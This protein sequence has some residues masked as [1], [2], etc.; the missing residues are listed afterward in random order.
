MHDGTLPTLASVLTHYAGGFVKRPAIATHM[1]RKLRL[2]ARE[3][4]DLIAFLR[5]LSSEAQRP[6]GSIAPGGIER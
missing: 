6:K 2:S 1:N 5:T 4:A 3:R